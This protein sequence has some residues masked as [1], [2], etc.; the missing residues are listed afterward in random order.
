LSP[1]S[2]DRIRAI[3]EQ[4]A[5][6]VKTGRSRDHAAD[7]PNLCGIVLSAM[8]LRGADLHEA[9][10][11]EADLT[12]SDL[13]GTDLHR[14]DLRGARLV[15]ANLAQ[16][17]L[18]G[19][20]LERSDLTRAKLVSA[21][22]TEANLD[23]ANLTSAVLSHAE[24][25]WASMKGADV[26]EAIIDTDLAS[27]VLEFK[28]G[29][30]PSV[31]SLALASHLDEVR[32]DVSPHS[33]VALREAFKRTGMRREE[34]DITFAIRHQQRLRD[35]VLGQVFSMMMFEWPVAYG[36]EPG[37]ALK[38]L[39]FLVALFAVPYAW[40]LRPTRP[41]LNTV[42]ME[43]DDERGRR[44]TPRLIPPSGL[45]VVW[46]A[47]AVHRF[48]DDKPFLLTTEFLFPRC[49]PI[50]APGGRL[51]H[52]ALAVAGGLYFSLLSSFH[53]GWREL[54]VGTWISRL[55]PR[56]YVVRPTGW[57]RTVSGIQSLMSVYLLALWVLTYFGRPFE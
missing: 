7:Q 48:C 2:P 33:L 27:V 30:L 14:A 8:D 47:E 23:H 12:G 10:L 16:A 54:N 56:E 53:M 9:N 13:T 1:G 20:R 17:D 37:R 55:Q 11:R 31:P 21:K 45:W 3:L 25:T 15:D 29:V 57:V 51:V 35:D 22:L 19:A 43:P 28:P 41:P 39:G 42:V 40:L 46:V 38:W 4:H 50:Q 49:R 32:Y 18:S 6:W 44:V 52:S 24:L 5:A 36:K 34:R 26:T